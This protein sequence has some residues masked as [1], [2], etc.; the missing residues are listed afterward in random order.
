MFKVTPREYL[1]ML[2]EQHAEFQCDPL[3]LRKAITF[4]VFANHIS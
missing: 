4:C 1:A 3:S 2:Q